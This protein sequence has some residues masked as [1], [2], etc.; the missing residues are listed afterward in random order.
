MAAARANARDRAPIGAD[1][2][3]DRAEETAM[4]FTIPAERSSR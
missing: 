4:D 1:V 2:L 3:S